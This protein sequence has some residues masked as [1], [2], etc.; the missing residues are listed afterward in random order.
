MTRAKVGVSVSARTGWRVFPFFWWALWRA[1]VTAVRIQTGRPRDDLRGLDAVIIGGGDDIHFALYGGEVMSEAVF[2]ED[3]D[4]LE[5]GLIDEAERRA[6][7]ILGVCRGAQL[8]NVAR[9]GS[10]HQDIYRAYPGAS[11]IST[12]LPRKHVRIDPRSRLAAIYGPEESRVNALHK[13]SVDRAGER[14]RP[15][16][17]D[18]AGI[19]QAIEATGERFVVGVQ[20]HPEFLVFSRRDWRLFKALGAAARGDSPAGFADPGAGA[21]AGRKPLTHPGQSA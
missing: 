9:G 8:I 12:P 5:L 17:W 4:A 13:Q 18:R 19:V 16:A 21:A 11:R 6:L 10:L 1:G 3:R 15:V 20:W 7:P 2:D 14:I